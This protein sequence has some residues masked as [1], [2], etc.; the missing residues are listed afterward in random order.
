MSTF[1]LYCSI[2][3]LVVF[4]DANFNPAEIPANS[5]SQNRLAET[6]ANEAEFL[7]SYTNVPGYASFRC[8]INGTWYIRSL[9]TNL[10]NY[11]QS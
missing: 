2:P 11:L 9:F 4:T 7:I 8:P 10:T 5:N 6:I 1:S 3:G